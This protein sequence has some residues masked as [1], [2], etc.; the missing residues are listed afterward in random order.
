MVRKYELTRLNDNIESVKVNRNLTYKKIATYLGI[1]VSSLYR[2]RKGKQYNYN[3]YKAS[4]QLFDEVF[5][6][7]FV[8][9]IYGPQSEV[10]FVK[11]H[12]FRSYRSAVNKLAIY[13]NLDFPI[14]DSIITSSRYELKNKLLSWITEY[15]V[16][17]SEGI[18]N[19]YV[20][21]LS[22]YK[23]ED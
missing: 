21:G 14:K 15:N 2:I 11:V 19:R 8:A 9:I 23:V 3:I 17:G 22:D 12:K 16:D 13:E 4:E 7:F 18:R 1:S 20:F 5:E 10:Y 6:E